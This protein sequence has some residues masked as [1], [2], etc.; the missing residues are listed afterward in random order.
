VESY[1]LENKFC[2]TADVAKNVFEVPNLGYSVLTEWKVTLLEIKF[3]L[4]QM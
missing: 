1:P 3:V 4:Q 2:I